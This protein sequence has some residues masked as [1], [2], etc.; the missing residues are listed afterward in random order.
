MRWKISNNRQQRITV[1]QPAKRKKYLACHVIPGIPE[2]NS[3]PIVEDVD[4]Q[5]CRH[6]HLYPRWQWSRSDESLKV[7]SFLLSCFQMYSGYD[8]QS[9]SFRR[10]DLWALYDC[11]RRHHSLHWN[12]M[13]FSSY[14]CCS[15]YS[16][17]LVN[18]DLCGGTIGD[19][20]KHSATAIKPGRFWFV[21]LP[22]RVLYGA[23]VFLERQ[24]RCMHMDRHFQVVLHWQIFCQGESYLIVYD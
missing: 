15:E 16:M 20:N 22:W 4:F 8:R 1:I 5:I 11:C 10:R 17:Y 24:R 12:T 14:C 13:N 3:V 6:R 2:Q 19:Y 18:D 9:W 23:Y 21:W 7:R